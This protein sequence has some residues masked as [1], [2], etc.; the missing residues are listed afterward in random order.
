MKSI[1]ADGAAMLGAMRHIGLLLLI[2]PLFG[3][4][5]VSTQ[6]MDGVDASGDC[7]EGVAPGDCPPDFTLPLAAGGDFTLSSLVGTQR[8]IVIGTSN[9]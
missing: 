4:E 2:L 5:A 6:T 8:V 7:S 1:L 9:W 3:C